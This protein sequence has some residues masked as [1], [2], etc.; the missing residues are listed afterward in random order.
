M[1]TTTLALFNNLFQ[2][3][4]L[5][6]LMVIGLLIFGKRL[7]EVGRGLGK[8]IVEFRKGLK[9]VEDEVEAE[10][11]KPS[12][13]RLPARD[14]EIRTPMSQTGED[15]RVSRAPAGGQEPAAS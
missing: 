9:G 11:N 8:G 10:S 12:P 3:P 15:V 2:G 13:Q 6:I 1:H 5:I 14:P 7:P 4:D